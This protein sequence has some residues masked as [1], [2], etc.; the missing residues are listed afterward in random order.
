MTSRQL[1]IHYEKLFNIELTRH[2]QKRITKK[3][4]KKCA[5]KYFPLIDLYHKQEILKG[6]CVKN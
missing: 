5:K 1:R 2:M 4:L 6:T 3:E